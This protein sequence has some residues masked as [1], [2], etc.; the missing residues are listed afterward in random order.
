MFDFHC[1]HGLTKTNLNGSGFECF[2]IGSAV[3]FCGKEWQMLPAYVEYNH[4]V[5]IVM[6]GIKLECVIE[7]EDDGV[8][9]KYI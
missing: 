3:R 1:I 4:M 7:Q 8:I 9:E 6:D 5:I 2:L